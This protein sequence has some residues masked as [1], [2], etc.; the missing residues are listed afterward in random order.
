MVSG[1]ILT[2]FSLKTSP[3]AVVWLE[4][5]RSWTTVACFQ[6]YLASAS[7]LNGE[8]AAKVLLRYRMRSTQGLEQSNAPSTKDGPPSRQL[9]M[10]TIMANENRLHHY[11][12]YCFI[13]DVIRF[14]ATRSIKSNAGTARVCLRRL[15]FRS[16]TLTHAE[17]RKL[18]A[19]YKNAVSS[20][21][22][23]P[24]SALPMTPAWP[25]IVR[26]AS[27]VTFSNRGSQGEMVSNSLQG[28]PRKRPKLSN[29]WISPMNASMTK[30]QP[31]TLSRLCLPCRYLH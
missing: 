15:R 8:R 28:H 17:T 19:K 9:Q 12:Y 14:I 1:P 24:A 26:V 11:Y 13:T 3:S 10:R 20:T 27:P 21:T 5:W 25:R 22:P 4:C 29:V 18:H 30:L 6:I 23:L 2:S 31:H 7:G 16:E